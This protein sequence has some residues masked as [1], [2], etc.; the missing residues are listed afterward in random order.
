MSIVTA[1]AHRPTQDTQLGISLKGKGNV[2]TIRKVDGIFAA[3][4]LLPGMEL[5]S[6]NGIPT[7]GMALD[8]VVSIL[9]QIT[10]EVVV[11]AKAIPL[12]E[13]GRLQATPHVPAQT[14]EV[15]TLSA[16][17]ETA[18][19]AEPEVS[20]NPTKP[21][22]L[23]EEPVRGGEEQEK[24]ETQS[25]AAWRRHKSLIAGLVSFLLMMIA[26]ME[27]PDKVREGRGCVA[28][29]SD[30]V[31]IE[32]KGRVCSECFCS[33]K[34]SY[35]SNYY[36]DSR[37]ESKSIFAIVVICLFA[38]GFLGSCVYWMGKQSGGSLPRGQTFPFVVGLFTI[39]AS[40]VAAVIAM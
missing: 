26:I 39:V 31:C 6:V 20:T 30:Y 28:D 14:H 35:D 18:E 40:A 33:A 16:T 11:E 29:D 25:P 22:T 21:S 32:S 7:T 17:A 10:G 13:N 38:C 12:A 36:C 4:G 34:N 24:E 5:I 9:R 27:S 37:K 15:A 1:K 23:L 8:E 19:G 2:I 3:S